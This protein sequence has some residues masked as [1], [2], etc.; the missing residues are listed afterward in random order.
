MNIIRLNTTAPDGFVKG[1][2][3]NG[4]GGNMKYYDCVADALYEREHGVFFFDNSKFF[5]EEGDTIIAPTTSKPKGAM[6]AAVAICQADR[7]IYG[8]GHWF[9]YN[10]FLLQSQGFNP[11][12][13]PEITEEEFY[14]IPEDIVIK[15]G[16]REKAQEVYEHIMRVIKRNGVEEAFQSYNP[17]PLFL[18][19]YKGRRFVTNSKTKTEHCLLLTS[20]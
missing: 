10:E 15:W 18:F 19:G 12:E 1:G 2:N 5:S 8:E 7:K 14:H 3:G 16:D 13:H 17:A 4:G 20:S 9:N 6:L 11:D